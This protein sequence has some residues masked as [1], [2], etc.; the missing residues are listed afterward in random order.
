MPTGKWQNPTAVTNSRQQNKTPKTQSALASYRASPRAR[1]R[2]HARGGPAAA[3]TPATINTVPSNPDNIGPSI[4]A[5]TV[6]TNTNAVVTAMRSTNTVLDEKAGSGDR[7][8]DPAS[9]RPAMI[10]PIL[11]KKISNGSGLKSAR[12]RPSPDNSP[13]LLPD[14]KPSRNQS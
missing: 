8:D 3:S 10:G 13:G 2:C 5:K 4:G 14:W 1:P 6:M 11:S 12:K 9:P 7:L